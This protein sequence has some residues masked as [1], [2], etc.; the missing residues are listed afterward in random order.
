MLAALSGLSLRVLGVL[1]GRGPWGRLVLSYSS[2][3]TRTR[4]AP[5]AGAVGRLVLSYSST[6]TRTRGAPRPG[7]SSPRALRDTP[8]T[9]SVGP[10]G[11]LGGS[12]LQ[13]TKKPR[14]NML[15]RNAACCSAL[16]HAAPRCN[17][18]RRV[19]TCCAA[20]QHIAPR[21]SMLH[22]VA[23]CRAALQRAVLPQA[24]R[25]ASTS[26]AHR[27]ELMHSPVADV[28]PFH[29]W[30]YPV[31]TRESTPLSTF[32]L[33]ELMHSPVDVAPVAPVCVPREYPWVYP[34]S[35]REYPL[36]TCAQSWCTRLSPML[37]PLHRAALHCTA[38]QRAAPQCHS[39]G[40]AAAWR[41]PVGVD[42]TA[43][44][45]TV[46]RATCHV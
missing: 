45:Y 2:T 40:F 15:R 36:S 43:S 26:G 41:A 12:A 23:T 38:L 4:G 39:S 1:R 42:G 17:T 19:A 24:E 11:I 37:R 14:C 6:S 46:H 7:A 34:V 31:S 13:H 8:T 29:P 27:S 16:Q 10:S 9:S 20:L 44:G 35:T 33:L 25:L 21:C 3:S 32:V 5:R 18:L 28:R 30:V 22:R